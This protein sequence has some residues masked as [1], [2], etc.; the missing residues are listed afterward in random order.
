VR[1]IFILAVLAIFGLSSC[2]SIAP[3][4]PD[5]VVDELPI[6]EQEESSINIPIKID[7]RPY[8]AMTEKSLPRTFK[9]NFEQCDGVSYSYK[10]D[11][12][13]IDFKG[14]GTE[15]N[16]EVDG[17]YLLKLNYC[18]ECTSLFNDKG[19]CI[20]PRIYASC[21]VGEPMRKVTVGYTTTFSI[22]PEFKFKS[23]TTL[24]KF[25]TPDACEIT[26]FKYDATS[27]LRKEV[28]KVLKDLEDDIDKQIAAIDIRSSIDDAWKSLSAPLSMNGYGFLMLSPTS[29]S[30]GKV[31]FDGKDAMIDLHLTAKPKVVSTVPS[32]TAAPS[33]PK[34][35]N[36]KNSDGFDISLDVI[37]NYDSLS[38]IFTRE[39]K[40]QKVVIKNNE[41]IFD[42]VKVQGANKNQLNIE[43]SFSGKKKGILY[44]TGT[45]VFD[46]EKQII[47]FPDLQFD[48]RTKNALLKSAKW[49]FSDKITE[50]MRASSTFDLKP[51]LADLKKMLEEELNTEIVDGIKLKAIVQSLKLTGIYPAS[52]KL[53]LRVSSKGTLKLFM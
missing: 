27:L 36:H 53:I 4:A 17:K 45:P 46:A 21:G 6:P 52:D 10:F 2:G 39:I 37:S 38:A 19:N 24:K 49:L 1:S 35:S 5:T 44:L 29:I 28:T 34:L 7:L 16:F 15:L 22:T 33:L 43:V 41:V 40:G 50:M 9:D 3:E 47:S 13:P 48:L 26:V 11:R 30:L 12:E 14:L 31:R 25:E 42:Q 18:P 51:Q 32:N 20:I 8:L 23:N